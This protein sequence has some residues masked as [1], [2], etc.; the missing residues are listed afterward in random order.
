MNFSGF[1]YPIKKTSQGL[2][3][4]LKGIDKIKANLLCVLLTN[5][6]ERC[7]IGSTKIPIPDGSEEEIKN[8]INLESFWVYSYDHTTNSI[9]PGKATAH[10]TIKDA[11]L[12]EVLLD[13]N[14]KIICTP[15]HLFMLRNG[16]Y[17]KAEDLAEKDSMMPL[18]R[19]K[20]TSGYERVYQP[21]LLNYRETH[22]NFVEGTRLVG[23]REVVHH[24]DLNKLNNNPDNLQWMTRKEHV[25]LHKMISNAF[26]EKFKNDPEFKENWSKKQKEGLLKYYETHDSP[27]KGVKLS[28]KTKNK[29]S[30]NKKEFYET[31]E[32]IE[33]KKILREKTLKQFEGKEHPFKG[34]QHTEETKKKM[35]KKRP[36]M[37][38]EN[39]P[40]KREDVREKLRLSWI[41]RRGESFKDEKLN[42]HKII[43]VTKLDYTEDCYDLKVETYHN[44]AVSSGV[45][46]HNCMLPNFGTPLR[47]ILFDPNDEILAEKAK[48]MIITSIKKW[49][50]RVVINAIDIYS[51]Y[52]EE[53]NENGNSSAHILYIKIM[54]SDPEN[55]SEIQELKLEL[56][57]ST[58]NN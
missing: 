21:Y 24:K 40:S 32:G 29:L 26:M 52:D 19:N 55:I 45:F 22:L 3:S 44:F 54:F 30:K 2:L 46:V 50:P 41:K 9:K 34:K 10:L 58:G 16:E 15:D 38:G 20:N 12:V 1:P 5:P 11:N 33:V 25:D 28:Q 13:N 27:R 23:L 36:S 31:K 8:L 53:D 18:Y 49:E 6:G 17:K 14:E 42:N 43:S 37:V 39:N 48:Q 51:N 35:K 47:D 57:L 4:S 7:L 56:P